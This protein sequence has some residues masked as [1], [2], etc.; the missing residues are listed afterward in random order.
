MTIEFDIQGGVAQVVINRPDALNALDSRS[1]KQLESVIRE[2]DTHPEVRVVTLTGFGD[3]AFCVGSDLKEDL[4]EHP[5]HDV[6]L[7]VPRSRS[8]VSLTSRKPVVAAIAGYCL[9]GGL[10]LALAADI[11]IAADTAV[12]GLPELAVGS[13]P[14]AAGVV[15]LVQALPRSLAVQMILTSS[16]IDA[17]TA[18]RHGLVSEV[19]GADEL[20]SRADDLARRIASAP[21]LPVAAVKRSIALADD[22]DIAAQITQEELLYGLIAYSQDRAE[23]RAAFREKRAPVFHGA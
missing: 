14:G 20:R 9:G 1:M 16:R 11:R 10:E 22:R 19:T 5:V 21:P 6:L 15:R 17:E 7:G 18:L 3:R 13:Y 8:I 2:A 12:F 4:T 23:G